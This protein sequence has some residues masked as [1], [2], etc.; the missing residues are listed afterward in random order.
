MKTQLAQM[1]LEERQGKLLEVDEVRKT[2][3]E[4][5]RTMR[6][7]CLELPDRLADELAN[8]RNAGR[9][10]AIMMR[11]ITEVLRK[12]ASRFEAAGMAAAAVGVAGQSDG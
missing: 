3:F 11:E 5:I 6:N 1:S 8:E 7:Q 2:L 9:V 4:I 12:L 10:R